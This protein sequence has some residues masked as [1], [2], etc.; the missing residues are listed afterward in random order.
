MKYQNKTLLP[1]FL[2]SALTIV[3][4]EEQPQ[5]KLEEK[6]EEQFASEVIAEDVVEIP[7]TI[8]S[9]TLIN[10]PTPLPEGYKV[11]TTHLKKPMM[12]DFDGDGKLDAFRVIKNP[13]KS[14]MKYLFEFRIADSDKVYFYESEDKEYD[15]DGFGTFE[16]APKSEIYVD[17][18]H[19]FDKDNNILVN[20]EIDPKYYLKFKGNGIMVNVLEE[21]CAASV[22][23][24]D[25]EK[26]RRIYLC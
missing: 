17:D 15:L 19:R 13:N 1:L 25:N 21:T 20:E 6:I 4:C 22:F 2:I 24:L 9:K 8:Q 16:L 14:G 11:D 10:N 3:A 7:A 26:I 18:E 5:P 23:F 12:I